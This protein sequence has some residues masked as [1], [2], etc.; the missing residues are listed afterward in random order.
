MTSETAETKDPRRV[1]ETDLRA[2][3]GKKQRNAWVDPRKEV[4]VDLWKGPTKEDSSV[5]RGRDRK[6]LIED[7][8]VIAVNLNVGCSSE[9]REREGGNKMES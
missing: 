8:V 2:W 3:R 6:A 9:K 1:H 4:A 7:I 5:V